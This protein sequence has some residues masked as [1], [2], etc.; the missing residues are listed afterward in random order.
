MQI[1]ETGTPRAA[2]P[3]SAKPRLVNSHGAA[4]D[5]PGC[6]WAPERRDTSLPVPVGAT[7]LGLVVKLLHGGVH[8]GS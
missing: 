5:G 4:S 7:Q 2:V 3:V 6:G 1:S 8:D